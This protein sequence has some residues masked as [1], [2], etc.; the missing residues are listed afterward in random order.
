MAT[1]EPVML[2][3]EIRDGHLKA[4][5]QHGRLVSGIRTIRVNTD[6]KG[7]TEITVKVVA[8]LPDGALIK[9]KVSDG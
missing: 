3:A 8:K 5:D 6:Y 4:V 2:H 9:M 7:V 1:D